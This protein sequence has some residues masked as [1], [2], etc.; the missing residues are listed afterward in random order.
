MENVWRPND[1]KRSSGTSSSLSRTEGESRGWSEGRSEGT[2]RGTSHSQTDGTSE[3]VTTGTS[4]TEGITRG[5]SQSRSSGANETIQ[6]RAL[7]TPDEIGQLFGRVDDKGRAAYPGM[8]LIV[9]SGARPVAVRRVNY[10]E[11]YQFIGL[12]DPNPDY[13]FATWAELSVEGSQLGFAL[14]DYGLSLGAWSITIKQIAAGGGEAVAVL[15]DAGAAP[16]AW[17]RVPRLG[18]IRTLPAAGQSEL[19]AGPVFSLRHYR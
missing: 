3:S 8:A 10:F 7:V 13:P 17:I 19:P 14:A 1:V 15:K 18:V 6:K 2:S 11:D 5:T 4:E 16:V 12:F 9:L